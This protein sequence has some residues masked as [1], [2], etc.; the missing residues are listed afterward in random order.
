MFYRDLIVTTGNRGVIALPQSLRF[1]IWYGVTFL[2][3]AMP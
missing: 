3:D 1:P 2:A